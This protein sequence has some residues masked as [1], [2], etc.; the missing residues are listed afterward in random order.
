MRKNII[1]KMIKNYNLFLINEGITISNDDIVDIIKSLE[2]EDN[3]N[4]LLIN[5]LVNHTDNKGKNVLMNIV[6]TNNEEL[7]DYVLKFNVDINHKTKTGE[8]VLFF[9]KNVKIFNKF[10][11]LGADVTAKNKNKRNILTYLAS[12]KI[13]NIELYQKLI[14]DGVDINQ[15]DDGGF[16]VLTE[17][18]MNKGIVELLIKNKVNLNDITQNV[19]L[20]KLFDKIKFYKNK[21]T[22]VIKIFELLFKNGM[23]VENSVVFLEQ[24]CSMSN[25]GN[26][27]TDFIKPLKSYF[28]GKMLIKI[29]GFRFLYKKGRY[30][31]G[32][33]AIKFAQELLNLD[34]YPDLYNHFKNVYGKEF[35]YHFEDFIKKHPYLDDSEK[36]NL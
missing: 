11:N 21:K 24:L 12:K 14:N 13:F 1:Y 8:N 6:Q 10:Y 36:Y 22:A 33:G 35:Q 30:S 25:I 7:I 4:S 16:S 2:S 15:F 5:R 34:L 3:K 19:Y 9:C 32:A 20:I 31:W 28:S 23:D 18:I 26:I 27:V 29:F 17:S